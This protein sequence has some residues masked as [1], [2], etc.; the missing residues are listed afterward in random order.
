MLQSAES[1]F[2][3]ITF[4]REHAVQ[5]PDLSIQGNDIIDRKVREMVEHA[6]HN[7]DCIINIGN[8][9]YRPTPGDIQE[10]LELRK[11]LQN[12]ESRVRKLVKK[13]RYMMETFNSWEK[14]AEYAAQIRNKR[15]TAGTQ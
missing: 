13:K 8:G 1:Y 3:R 15:E 5:R 9:W 11:Y 2:N 12:D 4:G 10:K 7:G 14:E 6:N